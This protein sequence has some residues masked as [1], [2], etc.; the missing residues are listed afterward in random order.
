MGTAAVSAALGINRV[1]AQQLLAGEVAGETYKDDRGGL[2]ALASAIERLKSW[3]TVEP[4]TPTLQVKVTAATWSD[5]EARWRGWHRR[6]PTP[7]RRD[8]VRG[9]WAVREPDK[10]LGRT[11][12]ATMSGFVVEVATIVGYET[13]YGK[14]IFTLEDPTDDALDLYS[15]VRLPPQAGAIIGLWNVS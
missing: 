6:L 2:Q 9:W 15:N 12:V 14:R 7:L 5:S 8:G 13:G 10:L 11:F 3:P 4:T 1:G